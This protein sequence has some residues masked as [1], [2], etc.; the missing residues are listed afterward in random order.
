MVAFVHAH[1]GMF[2]RTFITILILKRR[3]H[4]AGKESRDAEGKTG[5]RETREGRDGIK[6]KARRHTGEE[7]TNSCYFHQQ[8]IVVP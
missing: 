2:I 8:T 3:L 6:S 4:E 5:W 7:M 1:K